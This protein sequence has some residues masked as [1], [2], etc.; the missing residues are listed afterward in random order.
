M[1]VLGRQHGWSD[2]SY[3]VVAVVFGEPDATKSELARE[4]SEARDGRERGI[5]TAVFLH[6]GQ[7]QNGQWRDTP[8]RPG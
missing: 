6:G 1:G 4:A 8:V 5:G 2:A 7:F 3:G